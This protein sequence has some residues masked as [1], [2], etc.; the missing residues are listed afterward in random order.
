MK[1]IA[2]AFTLAAA[3]AGCYENFSKPSAMHS[4]DSRLDNY[5]PVALA[6]NTNGGVYGL[7]HVTWDDGAPTVF[8][9]FNVPGQDWEPNPYALTVYA[10]QFHGAAILADSQDPSRAYAVTAGTKANGFQ[11]T[12]MF[13]TTDRGASWDWV[14][15]GVKED[16]SKKNNF[17]HYMAQDPTDPSEVVSLF[18]NWYTIRIVRSSDQGE[19][20]SVPSQVAE[21]ATD[22]NIR[23]QGLQYL[24]DGTLVVFYGIAGVEGSDDNPD[25]F[26]QRSSNNGLTW[27]API[28][29]N[30]TVSGRQNLGGDLIHA[31]GTLH[32]VW[33]SDLNYKHNISNDGGLTW[34]GNT[35]LD[36]TV[37]YDPRLASPPHDPSV[38]VSF[39]TGILDGAERDSRNLLSRTFDGTEWSETRRINSFIGSCTG[40]GGLVATSDDVIVA[41]W[42]DN[43]DNDWSNKRFAYSAYS[44]PNRAEDYGVSFQT[45]TI[46]Q[47]AVRGEPIEFSYTV[48]NYT[49][50]PATMDVWIDVYGQQQFLFRELK[51]NVVTLAAGE[52]TTL[53]YSSLVP[54]GAPRQDYIIS[55]YLD[56][57]GY[58]LIDRDGFEVKVVR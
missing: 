11:T 39:R 19:T 25:Y 13:L 53:T 48:G 2:L 44:D 38:V 42:Q 4:F 12:D 35:V 51:R 22:Y 30:N 10:D 57:D 14:D 15:H 34:E 16:V 41:T 37:A 28:R 49:D 1:R 20:W 6:A 58:D 46:P 21:S 31:D 26:V 17:F 40:Q 32:A 5:I 45:S 29:V 50:V 36:W 7:Y 43:F 9:T 3:T 54:P 8:P 18:G 47:D 27:S 24:D 56:T 52:E 33:A 23:P 55:A